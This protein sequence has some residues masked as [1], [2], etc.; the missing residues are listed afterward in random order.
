MRPMNIA[1]K[2]IAAIQGRRTS[3]GDGVH[4][5]A[6]HYKKAVRLHT[7][8][9]AEAQLVDAA[10]GPKKAPTPRG[11]GLGPPAGAVWVPARLAHA[12]DGLADVDM[13]ALY[14]D[15]KWLGRKKLSS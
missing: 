11:R 9:H 1:E 7:H 15:R 8:I 5:V 12:M 10:K 13:R 2:P 3:T 14:F 4:L 6:N